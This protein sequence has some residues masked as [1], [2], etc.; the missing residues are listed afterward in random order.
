MRH[1]FTFACVLLD[2]IFFLGGRSEAYALDAHGV[3]ALT[4]LLAQGRGC[5]LLGAHLG[6]FDMLRAF[7]RNAPVV[8]NPVMFRQPG[9]VFQPADRG[10]GPG[11][12]AARDRHR[13]GGCDA[14]RAGMRPAAARSWASWATARRGGRSR[15]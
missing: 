3:E 14:A 13:P 8:V 15:R 12:R 1:F 7:G 9:G 11:A 10:A 4:A 6:S 5:V 2:R